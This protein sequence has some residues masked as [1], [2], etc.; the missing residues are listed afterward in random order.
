MKRSIFFDDVEPNSPTSRAS[1]MIDDSPL[2]EALNGVRALEQKLRQMD[3]SAA[4]KVPHYAAGADILNQCAVSII[5]CSEH[6]SENTLKNDE[7]HDNVS[8]NISY[9]G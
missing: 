7:N 4:N 9:R 2:H 6:C 8:S 5:H 1:T 3:L